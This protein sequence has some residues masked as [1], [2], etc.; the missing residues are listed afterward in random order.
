MAARK[1]SKKERGKSG[2]GIS[3]RFFLKAAG[4]GSV[5]LLV[6]PGLRTHSALGAPDERF[7]IADPSEMNTL[8]PMLSV[9]VGRAFYRLNF[10][11]SLTRWRDFPPEIQPWLAESW[12]ASKDGLSWTFRLR[13]GARFHDGTE[14]TSKDVVYSVERLLAL[15]MGA[16]SLFLAALKP[17]NV[18]AVDK[19][20]IEFNLTSP[21]APFEGLTDSLF[22]LNSKVMQAHEKDG[23]WGKAWLSTHGSALGKDGAGSGSYTIEM[24]NPAVGIDGTK[25]NDH[26]WPWNHPHVE[27]I[28][29]RT[30]A[31]SAARILAL[32]KGEIHASLGGYDPWEQLQ[33]LKTSPKLRILTKPSTRLFYADL[34]CQKPPT[35]DVHVRRALC[36]AF[37]YDSWLKE[38]QHG[39]SER[40][41][42]PIS[43]SMWGSLDPAKEFGYEYNLDKGREELKQAKVDIKKYEPIEIGSFVG[44]PA[45]QEAA[46][47]LQDGLRKMGISSTI[48][49][50]TWPQFVALQGKKETAVSI[51]FHW[52][53]A[54]Y[55]DPHNWIGEMFDSGKWGSYVAGSYYKNAQVDEILRKALISL[56][57]KER[58]E[59][60]KEA[61]RIVVKEAAAI[62]VHNENWNAPVNVQAE[63]VRF[64]PIGTGNELRWVYWK[65]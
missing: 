59:L 25:F 39:M 8:D 7:L 47:L 55:P 52:R 44:Y 26:F 23:D 19:Y 30:Y 58:E 22:I 2:K 10:Y 45:C 12:E 46:L 24:Y 11:D 5:A 13:K 56:N 57:R 32:K 1:L 15:K 43:N 65:K 31:E 51:A 36:Y 60:Y 41:I 63:G 21:Y 33:D 62:F 37:N 64:C 9:D 29:Y 48:V 35:D 61:G 14:V 54:A 49:Q 40:C 20:T 42:G 38:V 18:K 50:R 17:G 27:K 6:N 4:I 34:H 16:A 28:G 3:R 53:S